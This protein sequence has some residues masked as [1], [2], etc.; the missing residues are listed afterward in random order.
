MGDPMTSLRHILGELERLDLLLRVQVARARRLHEQRA[1]AFLAAA[2]GGVVTMA[3]LRRATQP[4]HQTI[5]KV[6]TA[7]DPSDRAAR[8][9][10]GGAS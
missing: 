3:H 10:E 2:D 6:L 9:I 8:T 4:E 5:G 7:R 1:D